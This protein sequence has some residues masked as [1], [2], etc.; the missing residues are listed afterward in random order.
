MGLSMIKEQDE[1]PQELSFAAP[2]TRT[3]TLEL[4][5]TYPY[6]W[7]PPILDVEASSVKDYVLF[8]LLRTM[9]TGASRSRFMGRDLEVAKLFK[10]EKVG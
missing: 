2:S 9:A 8:G 5:T 7:F 4:S 6:S 10:I 1:S 3:V